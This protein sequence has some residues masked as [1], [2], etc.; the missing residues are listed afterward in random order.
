V[1]LVEHGMVV[2]LGGGSTAAFAI[3]A[4]ARRHRQG[5]RFMGIPTSDI[6]AAMMA[7]PLNVAFA[8]RFN[9]SA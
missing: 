4:L 2:G 5:L 6:R 8:R 7:D 3:E 9:R 1:D